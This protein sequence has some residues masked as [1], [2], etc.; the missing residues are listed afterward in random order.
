MTTTSTTTISATK[1]VTTT[2]TTSTAATTST[3]TTASVT[4]RTVCLQ[5]SPPR[6]VGHHEDPLN[7]TTTTM[8]EKQDFFLC[9][10]TILSTT[11]TSATTHINNNYY[12][13]NIINN[14]ISNN[15][16]N[17]NDNNSNNT[18]SHNITMLSIKDGK[19]AEE[20]SKFKYLGSILSSDN[21]ADAEVESRINRTSQVFRSISRL[22]W[23]QPKIKVLTKLKLFKAIIL[24][25]LLYGSET[26]NLLQHNIQRLQVFVK[27]CLRI[28]T[29]TS[30]WVKMR[31]TQLR[32]KANINRV[33]VMIQKRRLQW[34]GH[35]ERMHDDRLPK[36]LLVS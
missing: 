30:L 33:D 5:V 26:W 7:S 22:V 28:I 6:S 13:S 1:P 15:N 36:K 11:T 35:V 12:F 31:N 19:N 14:H 9:T 23:Y 10:T 34:L 4:T 24:P 18:N 17:T 27:R 3:T 32:N 8:S 20:V 25:T 16:S 21:T 2:T 29:G